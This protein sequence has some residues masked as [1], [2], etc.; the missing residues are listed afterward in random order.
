MRKAVWV[1]AFLMIVFLIQ[2]LA[3]MGV[4]LANPYS[5]HQITHPTLVARFP[6]SQFFEHSSLEH[7]FIYRKNSFNLT[8]NYML[9]NN[10]T[11]IDSFSYNIDDNPFCPLN[12]TNIARNLFGDISYSVFNNVEN[13]SSGTYNLKAYAKFVNGTTTQIMDSYV[14]IDITNPL[15]FPID[16]KSVV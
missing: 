7:P 3:Q 13:L 4:V 5:S 1:T 15:E 10:Y 6:S 11:Q 2:P 14:E 8:L 9:P 12:I 16:R